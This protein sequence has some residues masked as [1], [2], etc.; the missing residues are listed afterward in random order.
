MEKNDRRSFLRR[1]FLGLAATVT[2]GRLVYAG[3]KTEHAFPV[4]KNDTPSLITRRLGKTDMVVPV[5]SMGVMRA[6][7][8]ALVRAA[9]DKGIRLLDT[10]HTYQ[11]GRNEEM[12][13]KILKDVPRNSYY[14]ATKVKPDGYDKTKGDFTDDEKVKRTFREKF[15]IS[16]KRLGIGY[17]DI[18]FL[19]AINSRA[20]TL[21]RAVQEV[22]QEIKEEGRTRYLG[23]S[24]HS[25]EPEV[26]RAAVDSGVY[27]V[28]LVA[29]NYRQDHK[30]EILKALEEAHKAGI[31]VIVMKTM[32]GGRPPKSGPALS[33][34]TALKWSLQSEYVATSI[35]GFTSFDQLEEDIAV[36]RDLTFTEEEKQ[37]IA[38]A[39]RGDTLYC[40]A[41]DEC[42]DQC[43]H[44]LPI[45]DLMRAYMYTYG[46]RETRK[47]REL[48]DHL[49]VTPGAC[50]SCD[51]CTVT[52]PK[53][54]AVARKITDITR[55][56]EM[57]QAFLT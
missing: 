35:P 50:A 38:Q 28:V 7:N 3:G 46:Y 23:V 19:H 24:T 15:E 30:D 53:G 43:P 44:E 57:P 9:L 42:I 48:L 26:I 29:Y 5:V 33:M 11:G 55:L 37:L 39:M 1:S 51:E 12:L 40:D 21:N 27:D 22:M 20:A 32:A 49:G 31:G 41:C 34:G 6:D 10:A 25:H 52:C 16:M 56:R 54:F 2:A 45:P 8:P 4:D 13:G 14:L 18:L 17:V 47:A 36:A